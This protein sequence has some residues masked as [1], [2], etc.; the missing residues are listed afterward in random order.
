MSTSESPRGATRVKRTRK[1]KV[2]PPQAPTSPLPEFARVVRGLPE[3]MHDYLELLP[4]AAESPALRRIAAD[5]AARERLLAGAKV[6]IEHMRSY[7]WVD[8]VVPCIVLNALYYRDGNELDLY[9]DLMHELTHLRQVAEGRNVWDEAFEYVDRPTEIEA[10]AV[11]VEEGRRLG[12]T[13]EDVVL[14][15]SNPW[16]SAE[17]VQKLVANIEALIGLPR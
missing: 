14:H 11:A 7:C 9:L 3:G 13:D 6:R 10:Y 2:V 8:V 15:L 5:P 4:R 17:D 16:M 1:I 12:M